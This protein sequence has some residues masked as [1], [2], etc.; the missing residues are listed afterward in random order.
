MLLLLV[1]T[2]VALPQ[3][4]MSTTISMSVTCT[5][6]DLSVNTSG[7]TPPYSLFIEAHPTGASWWSTALI[8]NNDADG[9]HQ[10]NQT[11]GGWQA[12]DRGRV[13]VTDALGCTATDS[14][15]VFTSMVYRTI[16]YGGATP[17][18]TPGMNYAAVNILDN[19]SPAS[20]TYR[21]DNGP[22]LPMDFSIL[23]SP[24]PHTLEFP[25]FDW[26]GGYHVCTETVPITSSPPISKP[27]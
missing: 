12:A 10:M 25:G 19:V 27:D 23:V 5:T 17:A 6:V 15:E 3:C 18:C 9:D 8:F 24:G 11:L 7:G 26:M 1:R 16:T 22:V 14:T 20:N 2:T 13:T 4:G 21:L